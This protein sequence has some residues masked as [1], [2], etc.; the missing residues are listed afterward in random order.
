MPQNHHTP[1]LN[2]CERVS[3]AATRSALQRR[4]RCRIAQ[5]TLRPLAV[6]HI[7]YGLGEWP[8]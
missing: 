4:Y 7:P 1:K 6:V 8:M 2:K 5:D 3:A